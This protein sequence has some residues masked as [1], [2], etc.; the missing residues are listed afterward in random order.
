MTAAG[1]VG[2]VVRT[3]V[4][5]GAGAVGRR[6][7]GSGAEAQSGAGQEG[8]ISTSEV[9]I[10]GGAD[11]QPWMLVE[12]QQNDAQAAMSARWATKSTSFHALERWERER[13]AEYK[14]TAAQHMR[15]LELLQ[16]QTAAGREE[17]LE[18]VT[19]FTQRAAADAAY[20]ASITKQKLGGRPVSELSNL[21]GTLSAAKAEA[22]GEAGGADA[23]A[24]A[25]LLDVSGVVAVS[26]MMS[27]LGCMMLQA[28][29][30]T[31]AG[32]LALGVRRLP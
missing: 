25:A 26:A 32:F 30:A 18:A 23:G 28:R 1:A 21:R 5:A 8:Q 6:L 17:Q 15:T 9:S 13:V 2:S 31:P 20:A 12:L 14:K 3:V 29:A 19:F 11:A 7:L 10:E 4:A 22:K 24:S 27:V 16:R